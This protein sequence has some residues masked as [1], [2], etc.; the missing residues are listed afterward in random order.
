MAWLNLD[1]SSIYMHLLVQSCN[2]KQG[3]TRGPNLTY[4]DLLRNP[5][6][7]DIGLSALAFSAE[8]S[9]SLLSTTG[10]SFSGCTNRNIKIRSVSKS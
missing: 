7:K 2:G 1:M 5:D 10:F 4:A 6:D 3:E 9:S 8:I